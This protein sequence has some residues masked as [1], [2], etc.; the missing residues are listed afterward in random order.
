MGVSL[1]FFGLGG[2]TD[3]KVTS[4]GMTTGIRPIFERRSVVEANERHL[5]G[6]DLGRRHE[7]RSEGSIFA[8]EGRGSKWNWGGEAGGIWWSAK[9]WVT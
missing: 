2:R 1:G 5:D 8:G 6:R 3:V 7:L 4:G 9:A